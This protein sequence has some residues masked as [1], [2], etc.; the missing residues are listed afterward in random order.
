MKRRL[1]IAQAMMN[2]PKVL[3]VDEPTVGL[4]PEERVNFREMLTSYA[5]G[6]VVILS[7]HIVEDIEETCGVIGILDNGNLV[8]D[9][10]IG[11]FK[12]QMKSTKLETAYMNLLKGGKRK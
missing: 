8:F 2:N 6:R 9:G 5:A 3:I 10:S 7:T 11:A 4:D 12:E 1:G